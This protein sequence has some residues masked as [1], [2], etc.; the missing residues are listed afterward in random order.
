[1]SL[2]ICQDVKKHYGAQDVL[3]GVTFQ[4]DPGEKLGLIGKNG[5]GKST[6]LRLV[7]GL[8]RP[9]GGRIQLRKGASLGHV[10]Q[11]PEFDAGVSVLQYVEQGLAEVRELQR[12][13]DQIAERMGH[14]E[15]DALEKLV[16]EH[17]AK[18]QRIAE[19]GGWE[20]AR[21]IEIVLSGIGLAKELWTRE[22]R[23]LSGGE[24]SRTAL[25]RELVAGHDLLLLD[26][27]TNHLDLA[28]IEWLETWLH[29]QRGAVLIVSHDRRLLN[30]AVDGI[31]ELE[32][33]EIRRYPGN[34]DK[35]V[36][37]REERFKSEQ[38]AWE[39]QQEFLRKEE[40]FIRKHMG[41]QRTAE[42]KGRQ[43]RLES[44]VRLEKPFN[45]VRRPV[46]HAPK[47]E[48]GGEMVLEAREL[49][50]GYDTNVLFSQL[51]LRIGRADRIGIVGENGAGKSTLLR[52]LAGLQRPLGGEI[53]LGHKAACG[54]YD[55]DTSQLDENAT[56]YEEIRR[57]H[58]DMTD[59]DIRSHL[60]K[61]LFRG[62]EVEKSI[63]AL[64]GGERARVALA[65]LVLEKPTW[66]ALDEPTN[67][68]DLAARAALE[69][70]LSEFDGTLVCV[71]HDRAFLD[72][73]CTRIVSV[74]RA[75]VTQFTGNYSEWRASVVAA[76]DA[77]LAERIE[78]DAKAAEKAKRD[79]KRTEKREEPPKSAKA[80]APG[81]IRNPFLFEKLE[82][83]IMEL[84]AELKKLN[85]EL[86]QEEVY[87][88]PARMKETQVRIAEVEHEL[89][90][91]YAEWENWQ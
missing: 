67:H 55:Q 49:S 31:L 1:M 8:E 79:E 88:N 40:D 12:E 38:R 46:I 14:A 19:L 33:G 69:E 42:A 74:D 30:R 89:A 6:I 35:Y 78:R 83:R 60:A 73:L 45:D 17:E 13:L 34:Y 81:K 59:L 48:R 11:M 68:L 2:L 50:G 62:N 64:S 58:R 5:G 26:E 39:D 77:A 27:P 41:S 43:K 36:V 20:I 91:R 87:R 15:G 52:I 53:Q 28:G 66:L 51:D 9:D 44:V 25:A 57:T 76:A 47:A 75:G 72:A 80:S 23:T 29:E 61:F 86:V 10:P 18:S 37:L 7:E 22:A 56:P 4:I 21:R 84:E 65:K 71:S 16:H 70:M 85:D 54:Y 90:L 3:R 63:S 32:R 82:A 24:R